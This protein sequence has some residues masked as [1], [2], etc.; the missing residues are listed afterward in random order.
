MS[1]RVSIGI[2]SAS[3]VSAGSFGSDSSARRH[4]TSS[5]ISAS[6]LVSVLGASPSM[7]EDCQL[8][9]RRNLVATRGS[10]P[11][12]LRSSDYWDAS[13]MHVPR[14]SRAAP[15]AGPSGPTV[16]PTCCKFG[17]KR[18]QRLLLCQ[19]MRPMKWCP[20]QTFHLRDPSGSA[21]PHGVCVTP[22]RKRFG[23]R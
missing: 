10:V 12:I 8:L 7:S 17:D 23:D 2:R 21:A 14:I 11:L 4:A 6:S 15:A 3:S 16:K 13:Q 18:S 5:L 9:G 19:T 1:Q 22:T 20:R